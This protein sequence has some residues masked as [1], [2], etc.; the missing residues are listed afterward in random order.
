MKVI[1][2]LVL[3]FS[4]N[5]A[6]YGQSVDAVSEDSARVVRFLAGQGV[7]CE[8][9]V[10]KQ[11]VQTRGVLSAVD[12]VSFRLD[13]GGGYFTTIYLDKLIRMRQRSYT[14]RRGVAAVSGL[15]AAL[16]GGGYA[17]Q[18]A[19]PGTLVAVGMSALAGLGLAVAAEKPGFR[20]KDPSVYQGWAFTTKP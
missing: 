7:A 1:F 5:Y 10:N 20:R 4:L 2:R 13:F 8:L 3:L 16:G 17:L 15:G 6:G 14:R 9:L 11:V 19:G 18:T 12:S